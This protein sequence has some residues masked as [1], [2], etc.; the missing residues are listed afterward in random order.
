MPDQPRILIVGA[1]PTGLGAAWRINELG[2]EN[3]TLY[4]AADRAG[5]LA[6]SVVD[7]N[8][9]TWD[10]G[11]HVLFSHYKYFDRLMDIALADQ[12]IEHERE[13]WV[14]MRERWIPY[15]FQYNIWRLPHEELVECLDGLLDLKGSQNGHSSE[16]GS[17]QE[18]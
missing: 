2:H 3:W 16:P 5:G 4:E 18:W 7:E 11:G 13:A 8:G 10:L 17:F 1:G 14:W 6:A 15:P 9:F 12:W